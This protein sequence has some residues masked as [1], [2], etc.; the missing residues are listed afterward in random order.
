VNINIPP[1]R[2]QRRTKFYLALLAL[3][4]VACRPTATSTDI[5]T[6]TPLPITSPAYQTAQAF[7]DAWAE[8][9]YEAMYTLVSSEVRAA[10][11]LAEF[12]R[13]Y[14][15]VAQ[16]A[17][18]LAV[19]PALGAVLEEGLQARATFAA[20]VETRPGPSSAFSAN[21][22]GRTWCTWSL[23]RR[24]GP[25]SMTSRVEGWPCRGVRSP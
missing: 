14:Q 20:D 13:I 19:R 23:V 4:M 25:T 2:A 22:K 10:T 5:P 18:I 15:E 3:A 21:W 17:T 9:K 24:C 7:L 8:A 12:Q 16:E 1:Q 6:S 11:P